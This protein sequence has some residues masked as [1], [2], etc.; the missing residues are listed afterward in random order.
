M[1]FYHLKND[2]GCLK[3]EKKKSITACSVAFLPKQ[4][5]DV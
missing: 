2:R 4:E 3:T 5:L 1:S